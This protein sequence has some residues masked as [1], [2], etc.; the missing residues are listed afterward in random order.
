MVLP[1]RRGPSEWYEFWVDRRLDWWAS[2][3][4]DRANLRRREHEADELSHYSTACADVEY[5]FP[6]TAPN[7][8]EL[9]GIAH[10]GCYDL[11]KHQEHAR[12]KLEYFDQERNERYLPHVIEPA[13]GLT[14]GV[15]CLL[16]E[17][18][19][20]DPSRPSKVFMRFDPRVAPIQAAV[21]PLVN[22]DGMPE[23]ARKLYDELR[24]R[25]A[26]QF[27]VKQS[28]GKRY[29]RM[30]EAGTPY[31]FTID[32]DS[33]TD[34]TVTVRHRD[35]TSQERISLDSVGGFLAERIG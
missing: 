35:T 5:R 31:C 13:G 26:V 11:S 17:A 7:F 32:S 10:R 16:C 14:R 28:V 4:L 20:P 30:D 23:V 34:Q 8:G 29:A 12:A 1:S 21:F 2:L 25:Y 6:F 33:L 18:Y 9:E 3:G 19:T 24:K 15:L 22:K 27:D